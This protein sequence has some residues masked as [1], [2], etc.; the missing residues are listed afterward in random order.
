M[1]T[2]HRGV[3]WWYLV[4]ARFRAGP[5]LKL[6]VYTMTSNP[7]KW[8]LTWVIHLYFRWTRGNR[9]RPR[10]MKEPRYPCGHMKPVEPTERCTDMHCA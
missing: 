9:P 8:W 3:G 5:R 4:G 2:G 10:P 7:I 1:L 6:G